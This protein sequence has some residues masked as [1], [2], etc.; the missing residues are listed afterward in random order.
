MTHKDF[1]QDL[2]ELEITAHLMHLQ[3]SSFAAHMALDELYKE[4]V[5]LR[6]SYVEQV[7]GRY[8]I[9]KGFTTVSFNEG[10]DPVTY[11]K[12]KITAYEAYVATVKEIYLQQVVSD[13]LDLI[14]GVVYKLRFLS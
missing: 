8:G 4:I 9:V 6:D 11:L 3:T 7:Q 14:V 1:I 13:V 10:Q 12:S 5:E 2:F